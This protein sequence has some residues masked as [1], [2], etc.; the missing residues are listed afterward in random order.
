MLY[1]LHELQRRFWN[2][3]SVW[4]QATSQMFSNPYSPFAYTPMSRRLAAGYDLLYR[5]GKHYEKPEF[6]L[7]SIEI[8]GVD[9]PVVEEIALEKPF[10][11][12]LHFK[13]E[14]GSKSA[15]KSGK[16]P[17]DPTVL[18]VAPL[19][20]HHATLLR[21]TVRTLLPSHGVYITD[22]IDARMVPMRRAVSSGRLRRL[23]DRVH[24]HLGP[25]VHVISVCQPTVPVLA[26]VS[27]MAS[28]KDPKL[29]KTM[30]MMGGPIDP[31]RNPTQVNNLAMRKGLHWF[32]NHVIYSVPAA[33][34]GYLRSVYPGF[35]QHAGFVAMNPDRH[36]K[37]HWDYYL[38]LV[39]GDRCDAEDHREFYDEY[40]AVLDLP[41]EYYLDTIRIVFQQ[42]LLPDGKWDVRGKAGEARR[43]PDG[44]AVH[45]RGR[46]RRHLGQR[47]DPGGARSVQEASRSR[48]SSTY[49]RARRPLRH[50]QRPPLARADRS[51]DQGFHPRPRLAMLRAKTAPLRSDSRRRRMSPLSRIKAT[52]CCRRRSARNAATTDAALMPRRSPRATPRST[53]ARRA[54]RPA[55]KRLASA[56]RRPPAAQSGPRHRAPHCGCR[57]RREPGASAARCA[58]RHAPSTRS[59]VR[60]SAM[61]SVIPQCARDAT[62]AW[63][64]ARWIAFR[65]VPVTARPHVD[66][67]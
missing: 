16:R 37:S 4:A 59:S 5:L 22:W 7:R 45:D 20:G 6:G 14:L 11:R 34:P 2:P 58:S 32:E 10:C 8:D 26:A 56:D 12:L 60:Q 29:P 50:L 64:P 23:C 61:H 35:L 13:R 66:R 40:N 28:N 67:R 46:A 17:A 15:D 38:D 54:A 53:S 21:D 51:A 39:K 31:R 52:A 3:L 30:T 36:L 25:H 49:R 43:H 62:C 47:P 44:R 24:P 65:M 55:S 19:S 48:R 27:L 63:R 33:Y 41:A 1:H 57:H 18:I 9:V 42:H